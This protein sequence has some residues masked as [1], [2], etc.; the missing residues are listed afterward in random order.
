MKWDFSVIKTHNA[1][2]NG[3]NKFG[4]LCFKIPNLVVRKLYV[5]RFFE[6]YLNHQNAKKLKYIIRRIIII[7]C[8]F[9]G[10]LY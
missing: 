2:L 8:L 7:I 10:S 1:T 6:M 5:E 4:K 9:Q 3:E